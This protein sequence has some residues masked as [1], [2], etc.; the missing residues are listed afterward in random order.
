MKYKLPADRRES[1]RRN[2]A[3]EVVYVLLVSLREG[4][5]F[6]IRRESIHAADVGLGGQHRLGL[7]LELGEAGIGAMVVEG[8]CV[9]IDL[10]E[11]EDAGI[12]LV[13]A[14]VELVAARFLGDR[15][16]G[17][18]ADQ[19]AKV[20]DLVGD[21]LEF[22]RRSRTLFSL[23]CRG[24]SGRTIRSGACGVN[25]MKAIAGRNPCRT[26]IEASGVVV[27]GAAGGIGSA[28]AAAFA[29]RGADLLLIDI[30]CRRLG[31]GGCRAFR[32]GAAWRPTS[33]T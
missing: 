21:D 29:A 11:Q 25:R 27:T 23:P 22:R 12:G 8:G 14:D 7:G 28:C 10:I 20:V 1:A 6:Q 24:V 17:L 13:L 15:T 5:L 19:V 30:N 26:T 2:A 4:N 32:R 9:G 3:G 18:P 33:R 16:L 31:Q